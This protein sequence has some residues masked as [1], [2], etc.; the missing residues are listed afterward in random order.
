MIVVH[1]GSLGCELWKPNCCQNES[2]QLGKVRREWRVMMGIVMFS[3]PV[4]MVT[5][6]HPAKFVLQVMMKSKGKKKQ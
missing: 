4:V 1:N 5:Q 6:C 2:C 3:V